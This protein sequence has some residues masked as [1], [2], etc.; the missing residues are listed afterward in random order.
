MSGRVKTERRGMSKRI[1]GRKFLISA[2]EAA[3][4][5][6][7]LILLA[8]LFDYR[9]ATNDDVFIK[10]IVSGQYSGVPNVHNIQCIILLNNFFVLLY[11]VCSFVPWFGIFMV[12]SQFCSLYGILV[13]LIKKMNFHRTYR[14]LCA[15]AVNVL[16][17]SIMVSE[18]VILQYTYTASLLIVSATVRLY[19][20]VEQEASKERNRIWYAGLLI[21]FLLAFCLRTEIFLFLLPFSVLLTVI[22]CS[23]AEAGFHSREWGKWGAFWGVLLLCVGALYMA[24]HIG[25]KEEGLREYRQIFDYRT[26]L[27]DFLTLPDYEENQEFYKAADISEGQY[28]LLKNYNFAL[29]EEITSKTLKSVVDYANEKRVAQYQGL[30]RYYMQMFTLPLREG[31]WSYTHRVLGDPVVAADDYPWNFVSAGLYVALLVSAC[32][33]RRVR[34]LVYAFLMFSMRSGLWMYIILRQRTPPRVTHSLFIME[35]VCLLLLVFEELSHLEKTEGLR[36]SGWLY[37]GMAGLFLAGAGAVAVH[38]WSG[39][40]GAYRETVAFNTEWK[41]LL[42]YCSEREENFYFMDVYSTVNYS[43]EI[44]GKE[45]S[46]PENY[47]ICGGWL[48]K[49]PLCED[50]YRHFGFTSPRMALVEKDNVFFVAEQ[51][52]DLD[53]LVLLYEE[54][55]IAVSLDY[56]ENVA[57]R[58]DIIKLNAAAEVADRDEND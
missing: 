29:D 1:R 52:S 42:E 36:K 13:C 50:K 17:W 26:Q 8:C 43:Q 9:Y 22:R 31:L 45:L 55:G 21:N 40:A 35:I 19:Y 25:Y 54:K 57:G 56:L 5:A 32:F 58:F 23:S 4:T 48:A 18:I 34:N 6:G 41:S 39:F 12:G 53:W 11:R 49:S 10:A 7:M 24:D 16:L 51:G 27:Y 37:P 15:A 14:Y 38:S 20:A 33:T 47:D 46:R 3:V 44:F 30:E 2:A 28:T